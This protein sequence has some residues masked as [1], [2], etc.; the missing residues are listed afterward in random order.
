MQ[1]RSRKQKTTLI[2]KFKMSMSKIMLYNQTLK[3]WLVKEIF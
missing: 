1:I 3:W 2:V